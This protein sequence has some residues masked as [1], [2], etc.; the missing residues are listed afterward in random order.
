MT[1]PSEPRTMP[2]TGRPLGPIALAVSALSLLVLLLASGWILLRP[3]PAQGQKRR[4]SRE[5]HTTISRGKWP[6]IIH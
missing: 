5:T 3:R 4:I 2:E 6:R 1:D